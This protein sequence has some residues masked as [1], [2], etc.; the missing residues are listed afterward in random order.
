MKKIWLI[1]DNT[2]RVKFIILSTLL[3]FNTLLEAVSISFLLPIIVSLT[4]NSLVGMY[5]KI[6]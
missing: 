1:F 2:S 6:I 3:M 5:P 4:D